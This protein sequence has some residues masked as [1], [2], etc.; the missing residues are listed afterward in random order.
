MARA[1][2]EDWIPESW[3]SNVVQRVR[4][5]S[6]VLRAGRNYPMDNPTRHIPRSQAIAVSGVAKGGAYDEDTAVNDEVLLSA[7]KAGSAVRIADEDLK[8]SN[9]D[10]LTQKRMDWATTYAKYFDNATL[11]VTAAENGTTV[12]YTSVYKALRTTN[13]DTG[14]T[15]DDNYVLSASA[16]IITYDELSEVLGLVEQDEFW[17]EGDIV[18]IAHPSFRAKLREIKDD[19]GTP[20]FVQGQQGDSGSPDRLFDHPVMWSLGAKTSAVAKQNPEGAPLLFVANRQYLAIGTLSG[21]EYRL[22]AAD[23]G[24]G[25]LTDEAVIK[26]RARRAFALTHEKA[27][28]VLELKTS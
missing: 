12:P 16:G 21:E 7:R 10:I 28:S 5:V 22:A 23:S 2:F 18:V 14:Y 20:I 3:D 6:A 9:V 4:Q 24:I 17:A 19:H 25:F 13:V 27:A 8:D 26:M 1:T 15:A 11:A